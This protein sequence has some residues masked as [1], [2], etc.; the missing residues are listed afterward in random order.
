VVCVMF[1]SKGGATNLKV[2]WVKALEG[3][4]DNTVKT[5][6]FEKNEGCMTPP[7]LQL[8]WWRRPCSCLY[9]IQF[10]ECVFNIVP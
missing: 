6:K 1:L 2:G 7:P 8:L 9:L 5:L 3:E 10:M 4:G